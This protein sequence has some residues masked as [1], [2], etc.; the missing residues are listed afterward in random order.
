MLRLDASFDAEGM[1]LCWT[2]AVAGSWPAG[3]AAQHSRGDCQWLIWQ[4]MA[5]HLWRVVSV[6][7]CFVEVKVLAHKA[8]EAEY[9]VR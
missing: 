9:A 7:R 8:A 4:T 5:S 3:S 6:L 1:A 2:R